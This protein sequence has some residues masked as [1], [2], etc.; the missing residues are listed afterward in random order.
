M[1]LFPCI[2]IGNKH[3]NLKSDYFH[4]CVCLRLLLAVGEKYFARLIDF[5]GIIFK[6]IRY[7]IYVNSDFFQLSNCVIDCLQL[8][9]T[10]K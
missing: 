2:L 7:I 9:I 5:R 4:Q 8:M 10:T 6:Y 3:S 1:K